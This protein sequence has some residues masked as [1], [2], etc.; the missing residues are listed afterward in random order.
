MFAETLLRTAATI[1][2][3][4]FFC[5]KVFY[6]F[7]TVELNFVARTCVIN[8]FS[9]LFSHSNHFTVPEPLYVIFFYIS[10]TDL[11]AGHV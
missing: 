6:F 4:V 9:K 8:I 7:N 10:L 3:R 5:T 2:K 1:F 11:T